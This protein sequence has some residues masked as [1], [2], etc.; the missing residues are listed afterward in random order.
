MDGVEANV[1]GGETNSGGVEAILSGVET[2]I[3]G[4]EISFDRAQAFRGSSGRL[5]LVRKPE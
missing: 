5:A 2:N 4:V 1:G 3:G